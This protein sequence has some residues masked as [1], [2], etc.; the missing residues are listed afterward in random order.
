[1]INLVSPHG[2][3]L[4]LLLLDDSQR[5]TVIKEAKTLPRVRLNSREK[6]DLIMLGIGAFTLLIGFMVRKTKK[7]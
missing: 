4:I 1:M 6:S 5:E 7:M 2:G 3:E